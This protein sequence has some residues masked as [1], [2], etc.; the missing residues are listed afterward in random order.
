M[1]SALTSMRQGKKSLGTGGSWMFVKSSVAKPW[2]PKPARLHWASKK[3]LVILGCWIVPSPSASKENHP[4]PLLKFCLFER[5]A[6]RTPRTALASRA[7]HFWWV[8]RWPAVSWAEGKTECDVA[9]DSVYG[10]LSESFVI[11]WILCCFEGPLA[12][13]AVKMCCRKN[14]LP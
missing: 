4:Q 13:P 6:K 12:P 1:L 10:F 11:A 9:T 14:A 5:R 2:G 7:G 3:L 8:C